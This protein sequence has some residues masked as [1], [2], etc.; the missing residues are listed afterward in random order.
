MASLAEYRYELLKIEAKID[1]YIETFSNAYRTSKMKA[2][3]H[4]NPNNLWKPTSELLET[5]I[6]K[7]NLVKK[8]LFKARF[9][10]VPYEVES[11][12]KEL[13]N[14]RYIVDSHTGYPQIKRSVLT[15]ISDIVYNLKKTV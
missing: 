2:S 13:E 9:S 14:L 3:K 12:V 1:Y 10:P 8:Y 6:V 15:A 5:T 11:A 4:P 7:L